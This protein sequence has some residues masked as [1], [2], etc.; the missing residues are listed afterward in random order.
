MNDFKGFYWTE[1]GERKPRCYVPKGGEGRGT[2]W[3]WRPSNMGTGLG[4]CQDVW[5]RLHLEEG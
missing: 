2:K 3:V 4:E 1:F 5:G